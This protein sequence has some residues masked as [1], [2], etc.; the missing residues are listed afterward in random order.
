MVPV[1]TK[2]LFSIKRQRKIHG[3]PQSGPSQVTTA[4]TQQSAAK[5][6]DAPELAGNRGSVSAPFRLRLGSGNPHLWW[7]FDGF[8]MALDD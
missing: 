6:Y 8:N 1:T 7:F 2:Q 4:T 3:F 5:V